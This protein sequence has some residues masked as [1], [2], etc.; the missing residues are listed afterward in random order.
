MILQGWNVISER[1]IPQ[2]PKDLDKN[3]IGKID[4]D[5]YFVIII[6]SFHFN[7]FFHSL[8]KLNNYHTDEKY[9]K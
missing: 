3:G 6:F 8:S 2:S 5:E 4:Q 1:L 7:L 9:Y